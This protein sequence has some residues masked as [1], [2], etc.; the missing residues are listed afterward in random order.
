MWEHSF[1]KC[2]PVHP[3]SHP[4]HDMVVHFLGVI[5]F[6][7]KFRSL[8]DNCSLI[9]GSVPN[10][11]DSQHSLEVPPPGDSLSPKMV[12]L[13]FAGFPFLT[14]LDFGRWVHSSGGPRTSALPVVRS[15]IYLGE[16]P[17]PESSCCTTMLSRRGPLTGISQTLVI[18]FLPSRSILTYIFFLSA[19]D[20]SSSWF[21]NTTNKQFFPKNWR[22]TKPTSDI[23]C[24]IPTKTRWIPSRIFRKRYPS[25]KMEDFVSNWNVAV[26]SHK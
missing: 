4:L 16:N 26:V 9:G 5:I 1:Q 12:K 20:S 21:I 13:I 23:P 25:S 22:I 24:N 19:D 6:D 15:L 3:H 7:L 2:Y 11:P 8:L 18:R 14:C 10:P 17:I